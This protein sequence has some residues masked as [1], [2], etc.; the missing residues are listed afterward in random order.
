MIFFTGMPAI[1]GGFGSFLLPLLPGVS[2]MASARLE[3]KM[4]FRLNLDILN[5]RL[6]RFVFGALL[7]LT[8]LYYFNLV[9]VNYFTISIL[10]I[11]FLWSTYFLRYNLSALI[12]RT[13]TLIGCITVIYFLGISFILDNY[14][15][16]YIIFF[17]YTSITYLLLI[18]YLCRNFLSNDSSLGHINNLFK[19]TS[20]IIIGGLTLMLVILLRHYGL[21]LLGVVGIN[22]LPIEVCIFFFFLLMYI[23][24]QFSLLIINYLIRGLW[25]FSKFII[26]IKWS[27]S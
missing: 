21:H 24:V 25:F 4:I 13:I 3:N 6:L 7:T 8:S 17:L 10:W 14:N 1:I 20:S 11:A 9:D 2:D 12:I 23:P 15:L 5:I 22:I 19:S 27:W 18:Y 16:N 26:C